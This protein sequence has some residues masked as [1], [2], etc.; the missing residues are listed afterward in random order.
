MD[1][2]QK[3]LRMLEAHPLCDHCLGRQYALL[4]HGLEN[5]QRGEAIKL[6]LT[7]EAHESALSNDSESERVLRVLATN[8]SS[9]I[10]HDVLRGLGKKASADNQ[11]ATCYLCSDTFKLAHEIV[12]KSVKLLLDFEYDTMLVGTELP[13]DVAEREDEFRAEFEVTQ[14]ESMRNEFGR[15]IGK[16]LSERVGKPVD[17]KK[18]EMVVLVNPFA[19]S[20]CLQPNPL[21]VSGRY[22]KLVRDIPQSKWFCSSCHGKGCKKCN[23]TGK[24]YAESVQEIV[25]GPFLRATLGTKGSFHASGREDID[26]RML[27]NGRPFVIEITE[28][29]KRFLDLKKL[30]KEVNT[31]GKGKVR[32]SRLQFADREVVRSLKRGESTQKEYRL[33]I[34]FERNFAAKD[35]S[36]LEERLTNALIEQQTPLRVVHRRADLTREKYIYEVNVKKMSPRKAEMKIRCQGGLYVKELVTGDEGRT[37][38]SV[39]EILN[40][41]AKPLKLDVLNVIMDSKELKKE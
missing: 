16:E 40:N 4:G 8:G 13:V 19:G 21:F 29:K 18:P 12:E 9:T 41:K 25:E 1:I 14:A 15:V 31:E 38:P 26:A 23:G 17:F 10:A 6:V 32:I 27:G 24:M 37:V 39:S 28:P 2:L 36:L 11:S 20:V 33:T 35:L 3:A 34:E 7:I 30:M 22:R 5:S